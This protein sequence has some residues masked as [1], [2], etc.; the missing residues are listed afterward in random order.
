MLLPGGS[1]LS[2]PLLLGRLK[3]FYEFLL[4]WSLFVTA[5]APAEG[6]GVTARGEEKVPKEAVLEAA[7]DEK[8]WVIRKALFPPSSV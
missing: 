7:G 8:I 5:V 4:P 1:P 2:D 6:G 3:K